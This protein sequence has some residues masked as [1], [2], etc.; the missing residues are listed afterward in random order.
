MGMGAVWAGR[1][2]STRSQARLAIAG[3][4][5]VGA[6]AL[7]MLIETASGVRF[8]VDN[9]LY[10]GD[11]GRYRLD[12]RMAEN[13]ALGMMLLSISAVTVMSSRPRVHRL[14]QWFAFG[15]FLIALVGGLGRDEGC[16]ARTIGGGSAR[17]RIASAPWPDRVTCSRPWSMP[18]TVS[19]PSLR[20]DCTTTPSRS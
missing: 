9:M 8:G 5:V 2:G 13:T 20:R 14:A 3:A 12:G 17:R 7:A 6:V 15:G 16:V 18:L 11:V 1:G 19:D 4:A 10:P